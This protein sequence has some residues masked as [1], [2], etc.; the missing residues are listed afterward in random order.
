MASS[1]E[2]IMAL[3]HL[4]PLVN[5]ELPLFVDDFH[6]ETNLTLDRKTFIYTLTH[7]PCLS[8]NN[9]LILVYELLQDYFV[10]EDFTNDF[11]LIFEICEHITHGH[12]PPSI[13]HLFIASQLLASKK[14]IE[15]I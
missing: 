12:V 11:D 15:G 3:H 8:S 13:S 9:P 10:F 7:S 5:V 6:L 14:Q 2:T 4:H 1:V